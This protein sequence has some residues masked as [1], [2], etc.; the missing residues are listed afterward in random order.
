[1]YNIVTVRFC[2]AYSFRCNFRNTMPRRK[3]VGVIRQPSSSGSGGEDG[4][5][6][7]CC[8]GGQEP[9]I[10]K[11]WSFSKDGITRKVH[12]FG[13]IDVGNFSG[14]CFHTAYTTEIGRRVFVYGQKSINGSI[15]WIGVPDPSCGTGVAWTENILVPNSRSG[16]GC[17]YER[18]ALAT[19]SVSL[20]VA[21]S[22]SV[23]ITFPVVRKMHAQG[24]ATSVP[25]TCVRD[26]WCGLKISWATST[27]TVTSGVMGRTTAWMVGLMNNFCVQ[28]LLVVSVAE[29]PLVV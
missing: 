27:T 14:D 22:L 8:V 25:F 3:S 18:W 7:I 24:R 13:R 5:E 11:L 28:I 19:P 9:Q 6:F 1:M 15:E 2:L 20:G 23:P 17:G 26:V 21:R 10:H 16:D 12:P 4:L 29:I